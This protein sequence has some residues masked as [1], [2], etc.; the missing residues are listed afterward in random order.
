MKISTLANLILVLL[1]NAACAA[2]V[3][4]QH[5]GTLRRE[6]S[7]LYFGTFL[8]GVNVGITVT[9]LIVMFLG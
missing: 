1:A 4:L 7:P 5:I 3:I 6:F 2:G 9:Y 8:L